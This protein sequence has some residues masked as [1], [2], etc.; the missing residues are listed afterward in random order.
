MD[1]AK[2]ASLLKATRVRTKLQAPHIKHSTRP[3]APA[4]RYYEG[5]LDLRI[6]HLQ[7]HRRTSSSVHPCGCDVIV[8]P[9]R[10]PPNSL[11]CTSEGTRLLYTGSTTTAAAFPTL[12]APG[13][14]RGRTVQTNSR[15]SIF[16]DAV[17]EDRHQPPHVRG[18]SA[19]K[20]F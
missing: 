8:L 17:A 9:R 5:E 10:T 20:H 12:P 1:R 18:E 4:M 19:D 7:M 2:T 3:T 13:S 11:S 6:T 14:P 15:R 16:V